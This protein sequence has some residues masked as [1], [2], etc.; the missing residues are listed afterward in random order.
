MKTVLSRAN[1]RAALALA[2]AL[3]P[4]SL[5][6]RVPGQGRPPAAPQKG[7]KVGR[8]GDIA[9]LPSGAKRWALVIGVDDYKDSQIGALRGAANDARVLADALKRY[10]GFPADQVVLMTTDQPEER[11]PTRVNILRRLSNLASVVPKDGL[12]LVSFSG[13]GMERGG[14]AYLLPSDAQIT[15]DVTFL[16]ETA[17]SVSRMHERIRATGVG[18]V[19]VLLDA[20]RN[21][22][23]GRA[24]APNPLTEAYTRGFSFDVRNREVQAFATLYATAVGHRAYEYSEKKQG[25]FT[26]ALVE[27][28]KGGAANERGEITLARLV[29]YVQTVVPKRVGIDLGSGKLQQP[30]AVVEGYKADGLVL[31]L[32]AASGA[33][34]PGPADPS[35]LEVSFWES[36][37][38]SKDPADFRAY[39]E[40]YPEGAFSALAR[41]RAQPAAPAAG[42]LPSADEVIE[43]S[44][45]AVGGAEA[46]QKF[47][48]LV[49]KGTY[50]FTAAGKTFSGVFEQYYKPPDKIYMSINV[51]KVFK[52]EEGFD[53]TVGWTKTSQGVMEMGG[54]QL[55]FKKR[56][57]ELG[58]VADIKRFKELYP[59]SA[60]RGVEKVEGRDAYAVEATPTV[61]KTETLYFDK[62]TGLMMRW[63]IMY[64]SGRQQ[65]VAFPLTLFAEGYADVN[66]LMMPMI[67]RQVSPSQTAVLRFVEVKFNVPVDESKFRK[68]GK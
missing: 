53:G 42:T 9:Q 67:Y 29:D 34:A 2:C 12:L 65:G 59:K 31:A 22:P 48:S 7:V 63:D 8:A 4:L 36:V 41:R 40:K 33:P 17:V 13:H 3:L 30:F 37:K 54:W 51:P 1:T 50:E 5:P 28:L 23:G 52:Q 35:S 68:P 57:T 45:K 60:V 43:T 46:V 66:G 49:V 25:Y 21:D 14:Y 62:Q 19:L 55:A 20:C 26:W 27:G 11:Q 18:Q 10:A 24:D 47:T 56:S 39:L 44:I 32:A 15:D 6:A 58:F 16:E 38:D 61:G 64:E